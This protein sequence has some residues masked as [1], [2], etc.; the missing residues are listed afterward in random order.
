VIGKKDPRVDAY[1]A[2]SA[3]FAQPILNRLRRL[4]HAACPEVEETIKWQFPH[5]MY[6]GKILCSMAAFKQHCA[7]GFWHKELHAS[8]EAQSARS[9]AMGQFGRISTLADLPK[10]FVFIRLVKQAT[11]LTSADLKAGK[12]PRP[13][14]APPKKRK[15]VHVPDDFRQAMAKNKKASSTFD[16]FSPSHKREYVEW[17]VE[18]KRPETRQKRLQTAIQW[19]AD[20]KSQNWRYERK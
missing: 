17:I 6:T 9:D 19:L 15:A 4:I 18:A 10:D 1:I 11:K 3:D 8:G 5:F 16:A 2:K 7:F 14:K 20:G 13:K 12:A